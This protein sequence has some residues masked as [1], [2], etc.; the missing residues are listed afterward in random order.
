MRR[1][2]RLSSQ[3]PTCG[4]KPDRNIE[5]LAMEGRF[6]CSTAQHFHMRLPYGQAPTGKTTLLD[7][8]TGVVRAF[9][10]PA[11]LIVRQASVA[12]VVIEDEMRRAASIAAGEVPR[13]AF[14]RPALSVMQNDPLDRR[15]GTIAARAERFVLSPTCRI[16]RP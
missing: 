4:Y 15:N 13:D 3:K 11:Y 9:R 8:K 14:S 12:V 16:D 10:P 5:P 2:S 1:D 6:V 7:M